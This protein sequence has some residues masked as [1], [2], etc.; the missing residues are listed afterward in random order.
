MNWLP[1]EDSGASVPL[2]TVQYRTWNKQ[3]PRR[4][5]EADQMHDPL[6]A[7][8]IVALSGN[9]ALLT[10]TRGEIRAALTH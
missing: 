6:F 7:A 4:V 10:E 3:S 2:A 8:W 9:A 5:A 1:Q